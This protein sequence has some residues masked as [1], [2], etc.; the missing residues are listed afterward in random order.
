MKGGFA[1]V[2]TLVAAEGGVQDQKIFQQQRIP[3]QTEGCRKI[4]FYRL[5]PNLVLAE[6]C[7]TYGKAKDKIM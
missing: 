1:I 3:N 7:S 4:G 5:P 6:L 2:C